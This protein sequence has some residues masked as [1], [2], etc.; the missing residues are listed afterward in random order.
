M[1]R[2]VV[3]GG[4]LP[5]TDDGSGDPESVRLQKAA[6]ARLLAMG[7]DPDIEELEPDP[8]QVSTAPPEQEEVRAAPRPPRQTQREA[9]TELGTVLRSIP[10]EALKIHTRDAVF[11]L[12]VYAYSQT[13][14][15]ISFMLPMQYTADFKSG[16]GLWIE[17]QG[18]K[19]PVTS[20][21]AKIQLQHVDMFV[22]CFLIGHYEES[23]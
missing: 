1:P 7:D 19:T 18:A 8:E 21:G 12:T 2:K 20:L 6:E 22:T 23:K 3:R 13:D 10:G 16:V 11:S 9:L 5:P 15:V 14:E 4:A 17:H